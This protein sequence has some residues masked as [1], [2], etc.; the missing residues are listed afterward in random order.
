MLVELSPS[1]AKY[2]P[3]YA[4]FYS[5][6]LSEEQKGKKYIEIQNYSIKMCGKSFS[7]D[8]D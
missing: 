5:F 1:F 4:Q 8:W 7:F 6:G 2:D 3:K